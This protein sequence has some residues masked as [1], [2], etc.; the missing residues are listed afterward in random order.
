MGLFGNLF[1]KKKREEL[2]DSEIDPEKRKKIEEVMNQYHIEKSSLYKVIEETKRKAQNFQ[3]N[4]DFFT[5]AK[6]KEV[7]ILDKLSGFLNDVAERDKID[8]NTDRIQNMQDFCNTFQQRIN[9]LSES[10]SE[11]FDVLKKVFAT[12]INHIRNSITKMEKYISDLKAL[13]EERGATKETEEMI[14]NYEDKL[15]KIEKDDFPQLNEKYSMIASDLSYDAL[16]KQK[17]D[18]KKKLSLLEEDVEVKFNVFRDALVDYH[19]QNSDFGIISV[20]LSNPISGALADTDFQILKHLDKLA[21]LVERNR[22]FC[23]NPKRA[24]EGLK[25]ITKDYL[26]KLIADFKQTEEEIER[27]ERKMKEHHIDDYA[28]TLQDRIKSLS[29]KSQNLTQSIH[30][31]EIDIQENE[32]KKLDSKIKK[33]KKGV[34]QE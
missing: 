12:E 1:G 30:R 16:L 27:I 24:F 9:S 33:T 15:E 29:A 34:S 18:L 23:E 20:Y 25:Y 19:N 4:E 31:F 11:D 8:I 5:Q 17:D 10:S 3:Q 13:L 32:L 2:I 7:S 21:Y 28:T 6:L 14:E 26:I 22:V